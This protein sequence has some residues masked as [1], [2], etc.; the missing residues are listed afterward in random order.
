MAIFYPKLIEIYNEIIE[1][2]TKCIEMFFLFAGDWLE[3]D[4]LTLNPAR[5]WRS[6]GK[7]QASTGRSSDLTS[8]AGKI[9]KAEKDTDETEK[10]IL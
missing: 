4:G 2:Y 1:I 8:V 3:S 7:T 5:I 6:L 9:F 10:N